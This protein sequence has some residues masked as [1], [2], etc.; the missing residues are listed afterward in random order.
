[1][2]E[3]LPVEVLHG[4]EGVAGF[5]ANVVNSADVGVVQRGSG[6]RFAAETREGLRIFGDFI[7][8][9]FEG[10]EAVQA[11]IFRLVHHAHATAAQFFN[12]TIMGNDLADQ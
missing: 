7:G 2:L 9:K 11:G 3:R 5:F 12:D 4:D 6:L 8:E 1:M 10:H